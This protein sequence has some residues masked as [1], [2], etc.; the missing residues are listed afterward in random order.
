MPFWLFA[1]TYPYFFYYCKDM[2]AVSAFYSFSN[3]IAF[4]SSIK[5]ISLS[6]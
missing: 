4:D 5:C 6:S 1:L 3:S 2:S